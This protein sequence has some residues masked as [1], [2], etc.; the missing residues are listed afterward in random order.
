[1]Q[2]TP[3][4]L[5]L[6]QVSGNTLGGVGSGGAGGGVGSVGDR[7]GAAA[8]VSGVTATASGGQGQ[9][10]NAIQQLAVTEEQ[11]GSRF[12]REG[13]GQDGSEEFPGLN[14]AIRDAENGRTIPKG[15]FLNIRV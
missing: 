15:S 4:G 1:M 12:R 10:Q 11:G 9:S 5:N 6:T 2:I 3:S 7:R 14:A 8:P 13:R